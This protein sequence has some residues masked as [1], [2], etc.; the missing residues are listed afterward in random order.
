MTTAESKATNAEERS[1]R[2]DREK[3]SRQ[4]QLDLETTS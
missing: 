3:I 4:Q 2:T 1:V